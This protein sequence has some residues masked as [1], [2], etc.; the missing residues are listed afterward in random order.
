[1]VNEDDVKAPL[2]AQRPMVDNHGTIRFSSQARRRN[3]RTT[4]TIAI[5][6]ACAFIT[7]LAVMFGSSCLHAA[8]SRPGIQPLCPQPLPLAPQKHGKKLNLSRFDSKEFIQEASERLA[9]SIRINTVSYDKWRGVAAPPEGSDDPDHA[10]FKLIHAYYEKQ[11]PLVHKHLTRTIVPPY[12]LLFIWP[13][14]NRTLPALLLCG[15]TDTV[16]VEPSTLNLWTHPPFSGRIDDEV[17]GGWIWGRGTA[18]TKGTVTASLEA[19]ERL[20]EAGWAPD[21][22]DVLLAFG[23]DEEI[24]GLMGAKRIASHLTTLGYANKIGML[25]DEGGHNFNSMYG[26]DM[27][28]VATSEKGYLDVEIIVDT[29]GGHASIPPRHT[30]IG[31]MANLIQTLEAQPF[32]VVLDDKNPLLEFLTCLTTHAPGVDPKLKWAIDH[33]PVSRGLVERYLDSND[34]LRYYA[35]TS[36][37]VDVINGGAK[38]NALPERV[39]ASVNHRINVGSSV[40]DVEM[41]IAHRLGRTARLLSLNLTVVTSTGETT[42]FPYSPHALGSVRIESWTGSLEPSPVSPTN[43]DVAWEVLAGTILHV[44]RKHQHEREDDGVDTSDAEKTVVTPMLFP[45]NTD[46]RHFWGLAKNLYRF[47]PIREKEGVH[48]VN[49]RI[50]I[51]SY[52]DGIKFYHELIRNFDEQFA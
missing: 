2:L 46:T 3:C 12:S 45:A 32:S 13:G 18:D 40:A 20:V 31:I 29:P 51:S 6:S 42:H 37:A 15:H 25:V 28:S 5:A 21:G 27:V 24:S 48:T 22:G 30:G 43:G 36:Q 34:S 17:D 11:F 1:M 33:L 19:V 14:K 47:S 49:E 39:R 35:A 4:T 50:S 23:Y 52:V 16:P 41:S 7:F 9:G 38:V 26:A 10:G 44:L 8:H